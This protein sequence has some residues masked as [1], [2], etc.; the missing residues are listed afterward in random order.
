MTLL[1]RTIISLVAACDSSP[2]CDSTRLPSQI[3][4]SLRSHSDSELMEVWRDLLLFLKPTDTHQNSNS[5]WSP[6]SA[7]H[8]LIHLLRHWRSRFVLNF[9]TGFPHSPGTLLLECQFLSLQ[10]D[11]AS[12]ENNKELWKS[13]QSDCSDVWRMVLAMV[14][15]EAH[16]VHIMCV[17]LRPTSWKLQLETWKGRKITADHL[18]NFL[19]ASEHHL[20]TEVVS[21]P[22]L[23]WTTSPHIPVSFTVF[24]KVQSLSTLP[25][26]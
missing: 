9:S 8:V 11:T 22:Q 15:W 21:S 23:K 3:R 7:H 25:Y 17:M 6:D 18:L 24:L 16:T 4:D 2:D 14:A 26:Q 10:P 13:D 19:T 1:K 5:L 12:A 20:Q